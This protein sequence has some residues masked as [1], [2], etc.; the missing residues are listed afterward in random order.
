VNTLTIL[1]QAK[2]NRSTKDLEKREREL[3]KREKALAA[4]EAKLAESG[5]RGTGTN[6]SVSLQIASRHLCML[7][8]ILRSVLMPGLALLQPIFNWLS[9]DPCYYSA[10]WKKLLSPFLTTKRSKVT[11]ACVFVMS[12]L[13]LLQNKNWPR[14][15]PVVRHNIGQD[16]PPGRQRLVRLGYLAWLLMF[17]GF[18]WNWLVVL[19]M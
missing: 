1:P 9:I 4:R 6:I 14:C 11:A 12:V 8:P 2:A 19:I 5:T 18:C 10:L 15:K 13:S 17:V 3:D 7:I 16:V